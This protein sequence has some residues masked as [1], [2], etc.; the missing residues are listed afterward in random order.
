MPHF[1][2]PDGYFLP[3][4]AAEPP[5]A[6]YLLPLQPK[7][8]TFVSLGAKQGK[9]GARL[10][11]STEGDQEGAPSMRGSPLPSGPIKGTLMGVAD[12]MGGAMRC[13]SNLQGNCLPLSVPREVENWSGDIQHGMCMAGHAGL[14]SQRTIV[15][16]TSSLH[17][18]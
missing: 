1:A 11:G 9:T 5:T 13:Y 17:C 10:K 2:R 3:S 6:K 4:N 7:G 8:L 12:A 16:A 15:A 18:K 14:S